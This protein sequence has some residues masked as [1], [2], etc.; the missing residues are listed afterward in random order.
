VLVNPAN[1]VRFTIPRDNVDVDPIYRPGV[2]QES[3]K[4]GDELVL[5]RSWSHDDFPCIEEAS[6]DPVILRGT[7]VPETFSEET[8]RAFVE[9]RWGRQTSGSG[10]SLAIVETGG[11]AVGM[12]GLFHRQQ[13]GVVGVGYWTVASRHRQGFARRSLSLLSLWALGVPG[14]ARIE[15]LIEPDNVS[16]DGF[17]ELRARRSHMTIPLRTHIS[18]FGAARETA[19]LRSPTQR[20]RRHTGLVSVGVML[21]RDWLSRW[22]P[23]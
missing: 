23:Q 12:M 20:R 7:S 9:R 15:A 1:R 11:T 6:R 16:A 17:G 22:G 8:G 21:S 14:I 13:P 3:P 2:F 18:W 5:L 19:P 4:L 10:L